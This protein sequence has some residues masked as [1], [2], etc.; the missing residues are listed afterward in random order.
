MITIG[1]SGSMFLLLQAQLGCPGQ[2]PESHE[3]VVVVVVIANVC[4]SQ[5][6]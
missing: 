2:N 5:W 6:N 1:V 4:L 3:T